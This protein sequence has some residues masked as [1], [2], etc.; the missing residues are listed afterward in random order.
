M[1]RRAAGFNMRVLYHDVY[2]RE[3]LESE[4][5]VEAVDLDTLLAESDYVSL[6][7]NLTAENHHFMNDAAFDKMKETAIIVNAA[8]GPAIDPKALYRA[9]RDGVI[10]AAALVAA[11]KGTQCQTIRRIGMTYFG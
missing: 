6:H 1:A 2:R 5:G 9:L 8:R 11:P 4:M 7:M 10:A 3:D